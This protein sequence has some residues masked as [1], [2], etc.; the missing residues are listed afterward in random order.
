M[1]IKFGF[2][3]VSIVPAA[4]VLA[5]GVLAWAQQPTQLRFDG[6]FASYNGFKEIADAGGNPIG[7]ERYD[8][9]LGESM[10][11]GAVQVKQWRLEFTVRKSLFPSGP[12]PVSWVQLTGSG[13]IPDNSVTLGKPAAKNLALSVD[14]ATLPTSPL[15]YFSKSK[16]WSPSK[17]PPNQEIDMNFGVIDLQ[18]VWINDLWNRSEGHSILDFVN[19]WQHKQ[20]STDEYAALVW[21]HLF[22]IEIVPVEIGNPPGRIGMTKSVVTT[23]WK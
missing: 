20:G 8:L 23:H 21:G 4:F 11:T 17:L 5:V 9:Y 14:V 15:Q 2:V 12:N 18:W 7:Y 10:G 22:G 13:P 19:S 16:T 1:R 6:M 3:L